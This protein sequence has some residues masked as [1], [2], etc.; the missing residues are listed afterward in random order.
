MNSRS[1][2]RCRLL[3]MQSVEWGDKR[4]MPELMTLSA[5]VQGPEDKGNPLISNNNDVIHHLPLSI[6]RIKD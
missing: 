5:R 1:E 4:A 2:A 3:R 6:R